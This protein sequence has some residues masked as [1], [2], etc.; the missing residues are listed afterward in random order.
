MPIVDPRAPLAF[1]PGV[2]SMP[3]GSTLINITAPN[4]A[5]LSLNHY[6]RF[7]VSAP[8]VV[9]NNSLAGGNPLLG[10]QAGPNPNLAAGR[11]AGTIVNEVTVPG[12]AGQLRGTVEVFGN[13]A[14]VIIANPNGITCDGCGVVNTPRFTLSTGS[15]LLQGGTG[16]PASF[17][18]ALQPSFDVTGG[19]I[20]ILGMG[21]E[22]TVGR[23]D[24][25][26]QTLHIDAPLRAHYLNQD[27]SSIHLAAGTRPV[28]Q[29]AD[30]G[31][32]A[33]LPQGPAAPERG[34]AI[35]ATALGAMTA[36]QIRVISTDAG[37]GVNLRGPLLAYQQDIDIQSAGH[38]R[39][40]GL[41]AERDIRLDSSGNLTVGGDISARGGIQVRGAQGVGVHGAVQAQGDVQLLSSHGGISVPGD[42]TVGGDLRMQ[43]VGQVSL[44]SGRS[45]QRVAGSMTVG[46]ETIQQYG[47]LATGGSLHMDGGRG[48]AL[49]G[50]VEVGRDMD[51]Q[52]SENVLLAGQLR[53]NGNA[54]VTAAAIAVYGE[55]TVGGDFLLRGR[56]SI[57]VIG[58][59]TVGQTFGLSGEKVAVRGDIDAGTTDITAGELLLGQPGGGLRVGGNLGLSVRG[60][61][62]IQGGVSVGGSASLASGGDVRVDGTIS[63]GYDLNLSAAGDLAL[64]GALQSGGSM[65]LSAGGNLDAGADIDAGGHLG[66]SAGG[67]ISV[68]GQIRTAGAQRWRAGG[69]FNAQQGIEAGGLDIAAQ[70][71]RIASDIL[72]GGPARIES[73]RNIQ[74]GGELQAAGS[75]ELTATAGRL[76]AGTIL[77]N[78]DLL[79][80]TRDGL[81]LQQIQ[82][83]RDIDLQSLQGGID[84]QTLLAG[85]DAS[86]Q[87]A[88]Q[89][90][91]DGPLHAG[92]N[93]LLQAQGGDAT[94][95]SSAY[96]GGNA[97]IQG[98]AVTLAQGLQ[99]GGTLQVQA[100]Q[101]GVDSQ[102]ALI[103]NG[104]LAVQSAGTIGVQ[105]TIASG[106][107]IEIDSISSTTVQGDIAAQ[108]GI[109][110][111]SGGALQAQSLA[112]GGRIDASTGQ[113]IAIAGE[114]QAPDGIDLQAA[115]G[116]ITL[117]ASLT[118]QGDM[119]LAARDAIS[120]AG[121]AQFANGQVASD[122]AGIQIGANVQAN[123]GLD[124]QG[125]GDIAIGGDTL[126]QGSLGAQSG[127]GSITFGG[128]LGVAGDLLA[129]AAQDLR[130]QGDSTLLG[131][132][133]LRADAGTLRNQGQMTLAQALDID[134]TGSV[135]NE[136]LIQSQNS[137]SIR[138]RDIHSN[139]ASGGGIA[140][141]GQL[142]LHASGNARLGAQGALSAG[143]GM[144]LH[145]AGG[146]VSQ[147]TL[148]AGQALSYS[149][150]ALT[151]A[152]QIAAQD[153]TIGASLD[154]SGNIYA[155]GGVQVSGGASNSGDI[156]GTDIAIGG[157]LT[158]SGSV[159]ATA[160][161]AVG[162]GAIAN[163]GLIAGGSV[164][165][166]GTGITNGGQIQ[167]GGALTISG[168]SFDN[169]LTET[170][171][172]TASGGCAP[173]APPSSWQYT[174]NPGT[175]HAGG[176][177]TIATG[178][179][180]NQGV[181]SAGGNA[182]IQASG[183]L[184][185]TR[186]AGDPYT[187]AAAAGG[188]AS[189]GIIRAGGSLSLGGGSVSNAGGQ[190]QAGGSIAISTPGAF[191]NSAPADGVTGQIA[192]GGGVT[193]SAASIANQGLLL[194]GGGNLQLNAANGAVTN[195]QGAHLLGSNISI[196]GGSF[197]NAG[198]VYG[199]GGAP[200]TISIQTSGGFSNSAEGT[201]VAGSQ[202]DIQS[203][204]YANA[205]GTVG[206]LGDVVYTSAGSYSPTSNPLLALGHLQLNV[207]GIGVGP[208]EGWYYGGSSIAWTGTLTN[209][210]SV[211][212]AGSASGNIHN[213][214]TG[215]TFNGGLPNVADGTYQVLEG[216]PYAPELTDLRLVGYSDVA[217]R[218]QL[219]IGGGYTGS[220][221]NEASDAAVGGGT[222]EQ[223]PIDQNL[224][225]AGEN[226]DGETVYLTTASRT[227]PRLVTGSG[228]ST[229][230]LVGP[231][232]GTIVGDALTINGGNIT[233]QPGIDPATG[234]PLMQ[235][236]RDR[237][238]TTTAV[239]TKPWALDVLGTPDAQA[240][241][242]GASG[243]GAI[244]GAGAD[245][246]SVANLPGSP[247]GTKPLALPGVDTGTPQGGVAA[248]LGGGLP[249]QWPQWDQMRIVPGGIS[250]NDLQLNLSGQLTN[251]GELD[252]TNN[253]IINAAQG[254]DNFGASIRAGGYTSLS[255]A[256]LN[257]DGGSIQA[258]SLLAAIDGDISNNRGTI[259]T[260]GGAY[261]QAGG[262]IAASEGRF[263]SIE[264]QIVL[265]AGGDIALEASTV[266]GK[267]GA[268]LYAG[269]DI[270]LTA[271][272]KH[273]T[274]DTTKDTTL[275]YTTAGGDAGTNAQEITF[276]TGEVRTHSDTTTHTGTTI[277]GG[278]GSVTVRAQGDVAAIGSEI[279]AGQDV[280]IQG[281][282]VRIESS[283]D[284][285]S[286]H[287]EEHRKG[288]D[289][290]L[291]EHTETLV[292]G[293]VTAGRNLSIIAN[294]KADADKGDITLKGA[295]V[296]AGGQA[297]LIASRDVLLQD[298]QTEHSRFEETYS[299]S[300]G[301]L[302]K[303]ST[304]TVETGQ[305]SVS[306]GS[307]VTGESVYVQAGRDVGLTGSHIVATE[308][309]LGIVAGRDVNILAGKDT[310]SATSHSETKK[311]GL[312][313][314]GGLLRIG[315]QQTT[316]DHSNE[317]ERA[318]ASSIQAQGGN[319]AIVAGGNYSQVGSAVLAAGDIDIAAKGVS[320]T[321]AREIERDKFEMRAKQSGLTIG[322]SSPL[323]EA[324]QTATSL[325]NAIGK[326][327][328]A[329][330]QALGAAA[331]GL[332]AYNNAD[333][334]AGAAN[335]LASGNP[336]G[337][338]SLNITLGKSESQST[339][340]YQV[341]SAA[342]SA[343]RA[344]GNVRITATEGDLKVRGSTIEAG[345]DVG[346]AAQ[347]G[348]I[349]LEAAE[350][351]FAEQN[352]HSSSS[353][354]IGASI[355][356]A[357]VS[358]SASASRSR[359]NGDGESLTYTN[360]QVRA[361]GT[362]SVQ[363]AGDTT[364]RGAT[365]VADTV[366][367]DVGG[368]LSIE[369]L[370]DTSR[371]EEHSR[372]S[373]WSVTA[374]ITGGGI[375]G[376]SASAGKTDI[377]SNYQSVG[378][379][380]AIRAGDGGFQV[381]VK[382]DTTLKGGAITS[383]QEAIDNN[384]NSF[385]TGGTLTMSDIQNT[386]R[387][388]AAGYD[389]T[390]GVGS[391]RGSTSAGVGS[392]KGQADSTSKAGI[393]GIAGDAKARTGDEET[394]IKPIFD[395]D[396]VRDD[397]NAQIAITA[398]F[399]KQGAK[400]VGT[401][402]D[403]RAAQLRLEGN[404]EE[405]KLWDEGGRYRIAMHALLGGLSGGAGGAAGAATSAT[406]MPYV[407]EEIAKLN[408]PEPMREAL[409]Q[410]AG[411][412][413]GAIAGSA[414]GAAS[415]LSETAHNYLSKSPF[416]DVRN[417]VN[418]E[419][420]RLMTACGSDCTLEDLRFIDRQM[421]ALEAAGNLTQISRN[422][423][424]TTEQA[425][426][427]GENLA[428]LLPFYGSPIAAYQAITGE[429]LT[430]RDLGVV[431]R[432]LN[433]VAAAIP[434][435]SVAYK[436]IKNFT[437]QPAIG[438]EWG[439][440]IMGQGMPW[441]N[442]LA[443]KMPEGSRLPPNFKTFDFFDPNTGLAV[444]AK[445]LDTTTAARINN[446]QQIY[447][448]IK[449][450]ID[451][452]INFEGAYTLSGT[453]VS[454]SKISSRELQ[455]AVPSSVNG[456][457]WAQIE[458]AIN[459]GKDNGINVVV[460][461]V[462]K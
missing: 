87:A 440:G 247:Y 287:T 424:L 306:E 354:S 44:G 19:R 320:I 450:N 203:G 188:G 228:G 209:A 435:T 316:T 297:S 3:G 329:R 124:L 446:P 75:V 212:I 95:Q 275:T 175:V 1:Q 191:T 201:L 256:S 138:A 390:I 453:T 307:I 344:D 382:G 102:G 117:G 48:V 399:G 54:S 151:S 361:G 272:A 60:P 73:Q 26:G 445:T 337:A 216:A 133:S 411:M 323:L 443:T 441:E 143:E 358:A 368:N 121:D 271:L 166:N 418:Q 195:A 15:V 387:Y 377:D 415:A 259:T 448:S 321:E 97:S 27:L 266:K 292:G 351:R 452:I 237:Q 425:I 359:G 186:S 250:A 56:E 71:V 417:A 458:R 174:Q 412:A 355:S 288:Y 139:T 219:Y 279:K 218:A 383:T 264:G 131:H 420:A 59:T 328:D 225:W 129:H 407:G 119:R 348:N 340:A 202:L 341:D 454:A 277:D 215:G 187:S 11:P 274:S 57:D 38:L 326:T 296:S 434:I 400:A 141:P 162:G 257:N 331:A 120:I 164:E 410:I 322:I 363:S 16:R 125:Q 242:P 416:R 304:H 270:T 267:Q 37:M 165:L 373:G 343:I 409:T 185:N 280:L 221:I 248:L 305:A 45:T 284:K 78:E 258:G 222:I 430:G 241:G 114:V 200:G 459:Y 77:T 184:T 20:D 135:A 223:R 268:G 342:G 403:Q 197:S 160:S 36:G 110:I 396:R 192:A 193:V 455:L 107:A 180:N 244:G 142:T 25:I 282:S 224:V 167:S 374:P 31:Y 462:K 461:R 66:A 47:H 402:A 90:L 206:S 171:Q 253:L 89:I 419:N 118:T 147:G 113:G 369:S 263:E 235:D 276:K 336:L 149:G 40:G 76:D 444:S 295:T 265:D 319:V 310:A 333:K 371:Y 220:L 93:L 13:P 332:Y 196:Q 12:S 385:E 150:G 115:A 252:V 397:V 61:L 52:A 49:A 398:E 101:G 69:D 362:A 285:A 245:P 309:S 91:I 314:G 436:V 39:T 127:T 312:F 353:S 182:S 132:T 447:Q 392:D 30:G 74:L 137:I 370:Q 18:Q 88:A 14:A 55:S 148:Q 290:A 42:L 311:S 428:A 375:P 51:I 251:R 427:L 154:N 126:V 302:S 72:L 207:A 109:R 226:E 386:A 32:G 433:G 204:G 338:A 217:Q 460:T 254:I 376:A 301:L 381:S 41:A 7:D 156:G 238:V 106:G 122:Q 243:A 9:L 442:Y 389:V 70:D 308:G 43:S 21:V 394:G 128:D 262:N 79:I 35:D 278:E 81:R 8:G 172:C 6:Q 104:S 99:A 80:R 17:D 317:S 231:D 123:G 269:G 293:E 350:N 405:A 198:T 63:A 345:K 170:R 178:T 86:A 145:A 404:E 239:Q 28:A 96:A 437:A 327:S 199:P 58:R 357:G 183:A 286:S 194:A 406:A 33:A 456:A 84:V 379:Q 334:I 144:T 62:T 92:R 299:K 289:H 22:G 46:G 94:V 189:T 152:G 168:T 408:L 413:A 232:T 347:K 300:S 449:G 439:K 83:L 240:G 349:V 391:S 4:A 234:L 176:P 163:D 366:K 395:K 82:A 421:Q 190:I 210:G 68:A 65:A 155:Q 169:R 213:V 34:I 318:A 23:L 177:L 339:S 378:E 273:E 153:I 313:G 146:L 29:Q 134:I 214:A 161:L 229:I 432:F 426:A 249:I 335:A 281:A 179:F 230:T 173:N 111:D 393:S 64:H 10:G 360:T 330:T 372:S 85:R 315:K 388:E 233:I 208:S 227:L 364:L 108:G 283:I 365:I 105:G 261:L 356:P 5:G 294:G 246:G 429:S 53:V 414:P 67:D 438:I 98:H 384:K 457:Q 103:A 260:Q 423:Q 158:N 255:G 291:F 352:S 298:Q 380:S 100:T 431:E 130:F 136:G 367:A 159:S 451:S 205:G 50:N 112:A 157:G 303:K 346:L 211:A 116:A 324:A 325:G 181:I 422:S 140:T 401:Y 236:A 2:Q 24:L